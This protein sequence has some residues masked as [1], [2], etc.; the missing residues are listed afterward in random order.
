M[1][2]IKNLK[3]INLANNSIETLPESLFNHQYVAG[4][5]LDGNQLTSLPDE[6]GRLESLYHF[7][8]SRNNLTNF[9]K[10]LL[11]IKRLKCT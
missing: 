8:V 10:V 5:I 4:I 2:D 11:K 9:S 1:I 3:V 7:A 6:I